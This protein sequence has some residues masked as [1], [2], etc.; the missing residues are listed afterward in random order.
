VLLVARREIV[1]RVR[2]R[3]FLVSTV[4][5][6]L[7]VVAVVVVGALTGGT[8][9]FRVGVADPAGTSVARTGAALAA[10]QDVRVEVRRIAA[11]GAEAALRDGAA[12][13]VLERGELRAEGAPDAKLVALLQTANRQVEA[14]RT[15]REAGVRG[16]A[17]Q[18]ALAPPP[19][20][21]TT[22]ER[23]DPDRDRKAGV[24]FVVLV[25]LFGQLMT[26]G[27]W[28]ATG[29]VEEKASRVVEVVL[30]TITPRQLMAGK[31]AGL[32]LLAFCHMLLIAV[33]GLAASALS[34]ALHVDGAILGAIAL[35]LAW[36]VVG[37]AFYACA[38]AC[39]GALVPRQDELQS[40]VTPLTM[41]I[42]AGY[43]LAFAVQSN[44]GGTLGHVT[45]FIPMIAPLTMPPRIIT[46]DAPAAE[47][48][49]SLVVTLGAAA[50]LIPLAARIYA[51][52]ILR[53]GSAIKLRE[54]WRSAR[55]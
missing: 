7:I 25:L 54:A 45:A 19:L 6:V 17:L 26:Y 16:A 27:M 28:V 21:V 51:G 4:I 48:V 20:R 8:D 30:A 36:F 10:T 53:T 23:V 37:Y 29:V 43:V 24:A 44:P 38:F 15:L 32:G 12:D 22:V 34:G 52:G 41:S 9:T 55:A 46:G 47:V 14:E 5:G 3:S 1:E 11:G 18:R 2:Q 39:A 50:A 33:V 42:L 31:V 49:A 40:V 13:V 35:S